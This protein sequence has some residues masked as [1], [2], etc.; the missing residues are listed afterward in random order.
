MKGRTPLLLTCAGFTAFT[1]DAENRAVPVLSE[2]PEHA[3]PFPEGRVI[4]ANC[5]ALGKALMSG[6]DDEE[7]RLLF[8]DGL[9]RMT[10]HSVTDIEDLLAQIRIV[11]REG[12]AWEHEESNDN[13][14]CYAVPLHQ[15]GKVFAAVSVSVPS[16]RCTSEKKQL[17]K[18]CLK[19]AQV[20]R[21]GT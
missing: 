10:K 19:K 5:T 17:V 1:R 14:C 8:E 9:C 3:G 2:P 21:L 4:P 7:I 15:R 18:E 20:Q 13:I 12:I 6:L 11:R 16:F